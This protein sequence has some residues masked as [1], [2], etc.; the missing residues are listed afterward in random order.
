M[1]TVYVDG[2]KYDSCSHPSLWGLFEVKDN[3][4]KVRG[5]KIGLTDPDDAK[6]YEEWI[7]SVIEAGTE[8]EVIVHREAKRKEK[9]ERERTRAKRIIEEAEK[10]K[11]IPDYKEARRREKVF[12]DINNQGG[13][14]Y[15]PHIIDRQEYEAA[16]KILG[17]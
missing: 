9:E 11:D 17:R 13:Y 5:L 8:P 12:N 4:M 14:G 6:R 3:G 16:L 15:V 1:L 10:Q 7:A 2:K